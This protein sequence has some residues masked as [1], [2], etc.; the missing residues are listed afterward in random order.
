MLYSWEGF[1]T[2]GAAL[3]DELE[4]GRRFQK[5]AKSRT[6]VLS[7]LRVSLGGFFSFVHDI[8]FGV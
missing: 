7:I 2:R 5:A 3:L 6:R 4:K 8:Y 1:A